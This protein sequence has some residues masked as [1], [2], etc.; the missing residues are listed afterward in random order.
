MLILR[1]ASLDPLTDGTHL[2]GFVISGVPL[3]YFSQAILCILFIF[4]V[5]VMR[6]I[7]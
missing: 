2:Q 4:L 7:S 3:A 1:V 6:L 5:T